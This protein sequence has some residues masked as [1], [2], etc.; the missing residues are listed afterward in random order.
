MTSASTAFVRAAA[1]AGVL[2]LGACAS[3]D[4]HYSQ[5]SGQR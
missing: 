2:V 1:L 4:Y 5:I 3:L